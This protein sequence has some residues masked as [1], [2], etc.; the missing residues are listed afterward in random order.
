M[1][2]TSG[3]SAS[4]TGVGL[5]S[6][7]GLGS[8]LNVS[9]IISAE[10]GMVESPIA[11]LQ[12]HQA[13]VTAQV[14]ELAQLKSLAAGF[15]DA[16]AGLANAS[17]WQSMSA[18]STSSAVSAT[19]T[20]NPQ[21][22]SFSVQ[23]RQLAQSQETASS[24]VAAGQVLGAAGSLSLQ[25]GAWSTAEGVSSFSA[26][27]SPAVSI[28]LKASDNLTSVAAKI[29]GAH[30]GVTATVLHDASGERLLVQSNATGAAQGFRI[31]TTDS[32]GHSGSDSALSA[33]TFDLQAGPVGMGANAYQSAQDTEATVNNIPVTSSSNTIAGAITGLSLQVSQV[34]TA[35]AL[36]TVSANTSAAVSSVQSFVAAYNAL[37][38]QL[39]T[40]VQYN[41]ASNTA[42]VL[43]GDMT[44]ENLQNQ[45]HALML[46]S[47]SS[48]GAFK[49]LSDVGIT[50]GEGGTL[51]VNTG[52]LTQALSQ[53]PAEVQKL[54]SAEANNSKASLREQGLGV[55]LQHYASS[56]LRSGSGAFDSETSNYQAT[57]K[58]L[59]KQQDQITANGNAL[60]AQLQARYAYLDTQITQT[61]KMSNYFTQQIGLWNNS[62]SKG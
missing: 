48:A 47:T 37:N 53:H 40:D 51:S 56:I 6:S 17:T 29:N 52:K 59:S 18:S 27:T 50:V 26:G 42:G 62:S 30:A 20:G 38:K 43:E 34:T 19:V 16:V 11:L 33:L 21:A 58:Q 22:T 2:S 13:K 61:T 7:L 54:F 12:A 55:Q 8:G 32:D 39:S 31:Q 1:S 41:T 9:A 4:S 3:T 57:I 35:P 25:L 46:H 36:V 45:L 24:A 28:S 5:I 10:V 49:Y 23:V 14:S 15:S 60:K 44:V